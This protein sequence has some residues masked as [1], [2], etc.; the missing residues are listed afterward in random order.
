MKDAYKTYDFFI[1]R[2]SPFL[3]FEMEY[4]S[5]FYIVENHKNDRFYPDINP[6]SQVASIGLL[7]YF[8]AFCKHQ[9]AAIVNLF[10]ALI[11]D[12]SQKR[13]D[14]KIDFSAII[15]FKGE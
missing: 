15:A 10:P 4:H 12:F 14:P 6:A 7:A 9:F 2:I 1:G 5:L 11:H 8:E 3:L 13:G